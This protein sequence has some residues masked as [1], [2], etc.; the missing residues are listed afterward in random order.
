MH[1]VSRGG[2]RIDGAAQADRGG[3]VHVP[4]PAGRGGRRHRTRLH[5]PGR[6]L[7]AR[8]ASPRAGGGRGWQ[9]LGT[10]GAVSEQQMRNL[11]GQGIHPDAERSRPQRSPQGGGPGG[12]R[13]GAAGPRVP[14]YDGPEEWHAAGAGL[15]PTGTPIGRLPRSTPVPE[16]DRARI[17]TDLARECS[18]NS[19]TGTRHRAG[20]VRVPRAGVPAGDRRRSPGST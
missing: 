18:P 3:R 20:T 14:V 6:L 13:C 19:T 15:T 12:R 4:D 10:V 16:D 5:L 8:R 11:F 7:R 2:G 17:R 9:S 1:C